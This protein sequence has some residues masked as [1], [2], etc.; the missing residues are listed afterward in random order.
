MNYTRQD[1]VLY[2]RVT[3]ADLNNPVML[4]S[5]F[6]DF[7]FNEG[8]RR[9]TLDLASIN[10]LTSLMIGTLVSL[11]LLAYENVV[12]L[13]FH[14]LHEKILSLFRLIG[15]DKLIEAHYT[16]PG[17]EGGRQANA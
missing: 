2:V 13:T 4:H 14:G 12:V 3:E 8:D 6:E 17:S 10:M 11:H 9:I 16:A 1:G 7:I 5:V 15:V